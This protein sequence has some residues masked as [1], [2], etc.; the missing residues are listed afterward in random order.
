MGPVR[1]PP[2]L[3]DDAVAE[4][5]LR[6]PPDN[7]ACLVRASLICK[8]WRRLLYNPS[9]ARRY[10]E[11]HGAPWVLDC[12]HGRILLYQWDASE[13]RLAVWDPIAGDRKVLPGL[14]HLCIP[15]TCYNGVVLCSHGGCD[16]LGCQGGH[17]RVVLLGSGRRGSK[18]CV[19]SS[20]AGAWTA[21]ASVHFRK[22]LYMDCWCYAILVG[23]N[24]L[25]FRINMCGKIIKYDLGKHC[26]SVIEDPPFR[27]HYD[28]ALMVTEDLLLGPPLFR[29]PASS[30]GRG[31]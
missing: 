7:P 30:C 29:T 16:H 17:F 21:P 4:I 19:H 25:Y 2:E 1:H 8:P 3:M 6:L 20:E 15:S 23:D 26:L 11:F 13:I 9:F 22:S 24:D 12:R 5:L 27:C 28:S 31:R 10:C 14:P 18:A